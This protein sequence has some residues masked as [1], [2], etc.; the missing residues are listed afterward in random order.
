MKEEKYFD[1]NKISVIK[2]YHKLFLFFIREK[3]SCDYTAESITI[4]HYKTLFGKTFILKQDQ[5]IFKDLVDSLA[6]SVMQLMESF[7]LA[8]E[9]IIRNQNPQPL[10]KVFV[11]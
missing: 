5:I 11:N 2:W 10:F 6:K 4:L 7:I 3:L 1:I 8:Q 9:S